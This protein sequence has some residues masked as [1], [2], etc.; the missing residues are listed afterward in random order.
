MVAHGVSPD[1]AKKRVADAFADS[2]REQ[3]KNMPGEEHAKVAVTA[4]VTDEA[5]GPR[6]HFVL[7]SRSLNRN[8]L[9]AGIPPEHLDKMEKEVEDG[10]QSP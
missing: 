9:P 2:L 5:D 10:A 8:K 1:D 7:S 4:R 6:V 3:R